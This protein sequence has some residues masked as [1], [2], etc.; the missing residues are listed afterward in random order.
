MVGDT[1]R[2]AIEVI[3]T[4]N[5]FSDI[6][7]D[8]NRPVRIT[9]FRDS[10]P[11]KGRKTL[12]FTSGVARF[13][14]LSIERVGRYQLEAVS[15]V[16]AYS[17]FFVVRP[18]S[19]SRLAFVSVPNYG[20][21][22]DLTTAAVIATDR[23]G[24]LDSSY[25]DTVRLGL[26][27]GPPGAVLSGSVA[28]RAVRGIA[29]LTFAVDRAGTDYALAAR[30]RG[31]DSAVSTSFIMETRTSG[32]TA[33]D[34]GTLG[35]GWSR[36]AALDDSGRI[37]GSSAAADGTTHAFLFDGTL[38]DLGPGRAT[39]I[40]AT[41]LTGGADA[42][43]YAVVWEDGIR[44]RL[45][46]RRAPDGTAVVAINAANDVAVV[47]TTDGAHEQLASVYPGAG[48]ETLLE[49][50]NNCCMLW[51]E[52]YDAND[53]GGIVGSHKVGYFGP[54]VEIMRPFIWQRGSMRDLPVPFDIRCEN[55]DGHC[56]RGAAVAIND[57]GIVVG[58]AKDSSDRMLPVRWIADTIEVLSR[59]M[60]VI[61]RAIA[62]N[63]RGH[64]AGMDDPSNAFGSATTR[65]WFWSA[66]SITFL[67]SLGGG[68]TVVTAMNDDGVIVGSSLTADGR[69]HAFFWHNGKMTDLGTPSGVQ[70]YATAVN[71]RGDVVGCSAMATEPLWPGAT[72]VPCRTILWKAVR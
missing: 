48:T 31:L 37:V 40:G 19:A 20:P 32:H 72:Y 2:P 12:S 67:G 7:V 26:A 51:T 69:R 34:I 23:F 5:N 36:A 64:V 70:S 59:D 45:G 41:G 8:W 47:Y 9:V 1:I 57:A 60:A 52:A 55:H 63:N 28:Q 43:Q 54:S 10:T 53:A 4:R 62:I 15:A 25:A 68:G 3:A 49:T 42:E 38:R 30:A 50:T 21:V 33:V 22:G 13:P 6:A 17:R 61:G 39:A 46:T 56:G 11:L 58:T 29:T 71:S 66:G 14:D 27:H 16:A 24:N 35:G 18:G 65:S 44:R